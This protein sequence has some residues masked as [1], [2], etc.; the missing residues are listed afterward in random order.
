[1]AL[2]VDMYQLGPIGT[3]CYV[4]RAGT[5]A[6]DVVVV[7]PGWDAAALRLE[8]ARSGGKC[9][10]ILVTHTHWDH[11]GAVADLA[12]GTGAPVYV[13]EG[14]A[15]GLEAPSSSMLPIAIRGYSD[16]TVVT[17]GE[18]VAAGGIEFEV[19]DV[20]GH[21]PG[22]IAYYAEECLFSGDVLFAGGVGRVDLPGGNWEALLDSIR[23]LAERFPPETGI[24]SGHGPVTTLG[25][26]LARNPFLAELRAAQ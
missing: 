15:P 16:A 1:M 2:D 12:E 8:I 10:A 25:E 13:S 3:N 26:E 24:Y 11:I 20:P 6:A 19:L 4:V 9:A 18:P 7:D 17:P 5:E 23:M 21:A 22:H 14:A